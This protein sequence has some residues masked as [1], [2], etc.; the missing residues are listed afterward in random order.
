M[1]YSADKFQKEFNLLE[2]M[3]GPPHQIGSGQLHPKIVE[4][5][6]KELKSLRDEP[7]DGSLPSFLLAPPPR[8]L[9]ASPR[10]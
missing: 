10:T 6:Y 8:S 7:V 4:R 9:Q 1:K 2:D 5:L 3:V